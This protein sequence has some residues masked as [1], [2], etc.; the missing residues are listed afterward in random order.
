M[1]R[2]SKHR[3]EQLYLLE[4][5]LQTIGELGKIPFSERKRN[6]VGHQRQR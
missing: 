5:W 4:L 6:G 2:M 1:A 3:K